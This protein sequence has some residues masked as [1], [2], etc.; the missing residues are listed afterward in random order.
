MR[1]VLF[2]LMGMALLVGCNQKQKNSPTDGTN[3][4][5]V[6]ADS[7]SVSQTYDSLIVCEGRAMVDS[8]YRNSEE[9]KKS[10]DDFAHLVTEMTKDM[11]DI[12]SNLFLLKNAI[13]SFKHS[14]E[15]FSTHTDEM[16]DVVNQKRMML[17]GQKIKEIRQKLIQMKL[18][19]E[20]Q[21]QLDSLNSLIQF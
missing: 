17:Y 14:S 3:F 9:Y 4:E 19:E 13:A 18:S 2:V 20:Q 10:H 21:S 8:L 7:L 16:R 15:Y 11:D 12:D 6:V 1:K 5:E